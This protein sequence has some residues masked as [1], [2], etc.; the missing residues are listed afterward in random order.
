MLY[1]GLVKAIQPAKA[2]LRFSLPHG[3]LCSLP[4]LTMDAEPVV[5]GLEHDLPAAET[6]LDDRPSPNDSS[7]HG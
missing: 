5:H 1:K 6:D 3:H 2:S 4:L 7:P